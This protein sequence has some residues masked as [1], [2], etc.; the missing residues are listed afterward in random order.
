MAFGDILQ[1]VASP[2]ANPRGI[3]GNATSVWGCTSTTDKVYEL[4]P[5]DLSEIRRAASPAALPN[6]IGGDDDTIWECDGTSDKVYE[7]AVSDLST[8]RLGDPPRV[9]PKGIGGDST[10]IW[11]TDPTKVWELNVTDFSLVREVAKPVGQATG[12]GGDGYKI[13]WSASDRLRELSPLD[14]SSIRDVATPSINTWGVG[15]DSSTVWLCDY[16]LSNDYELDADPTAIVT[17]QQM[18]DVGPRTATG[19][20]RII[21]FGPTASV[22]QH[23]H[24]WATAPNP[25]TA[26]DKTEL[27]TKD[28]LGAFSS[29]LADLVPGTQYYMR[30]YVTDPTDTYYSDDLLFVASSE[31]LRPNAAGDHCAISYETGEDCPDHWKNVDEVE[32]DEETTQV[33]ATGQPGFAFDLYNL[34]AH[35]VGSGQIEK[36]NVWARLLRW[37]ADPVQDSADILLKT[38]GTIYDSV[39]PFVVIGPAGAFAVTEEWV[40]YSETWATNPDTGNPWT[41]DEIDALQIGIAARK[42]EGGGGA[43]EPRTACTQVWLEVVYKLA[44]V[45]GLNIAMAEV[46]L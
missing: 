27:G 16:T 25:T 38:G 23:G 10:H 5:A 6:G 34:P 41:W 43:G 30:A 8:V 24:C 42:A 11:G 19:N 45:A 33:W 26:D 2:I 18:T 22:T 39:V 40:N 12:A 20:G 21:S 4:D 31:I 1:T 35:S 17:V 9:D 32:P 28:T 15:G 36:V 37:S 7:L 29:S 46:I 44:G 13:W 3:G 14:L